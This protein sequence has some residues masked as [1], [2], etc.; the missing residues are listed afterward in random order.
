MYQID[1]NSHF[2]S[3]SVNSFQNYSYLQAYIFRHHVFNNL[4]DFLPII[5]VRE[6]WKKILIINPAFLVNKQK[7]LPK[8]FTVSV[9]IL[10]KNSRVIKLQRNLTSKNEKT[11]EKKAPPPPQKK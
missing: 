2:D 7:K 3:R 9:V 4:Q 1:Y 11:K 10:K 5:S 8:N 6:V